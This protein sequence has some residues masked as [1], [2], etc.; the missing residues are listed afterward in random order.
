[1]KINTEK[2]KLYFDDTVCD[3][4]FDFLEKRNISS[5]SYITALKDGDYGMLEDNS[6]LIEGEEYMVTY[7]LGSSKESIYDLIRVNQ[8]YDLDPKEGTAFA[9]LLGDDFLFFMPN[10]EK[11][12]FF[13][14]DTEEAKE[15][16]ADYDSFLALIQFQGE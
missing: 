9:I 16:A 8:F 1:M 14:R 3:K 13:C 6:I 5:K 7:I 12:Y 4:Y 11:V 2:T 10:D 15:V